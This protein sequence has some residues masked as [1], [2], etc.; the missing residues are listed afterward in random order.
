MAEKQ[1][2]HNDDDQQYKT[3]KLCT[4]WEWDDVYLG[5]EYPKKGESVEAKV[6]NIIY[7]SIYI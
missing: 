3:H 2:Y 1:L 4:V 7:I 6:S 5:Y